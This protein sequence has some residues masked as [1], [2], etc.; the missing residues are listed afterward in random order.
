MLR[1]EH[2]ARAVG[3]A[4]DH[5]NRKLTAGHVQHLRRV[6]DDLIDRHQAEVPRHEFNDGP[7]SAH[8]RADAQSRETL[9]GNRRVDDPA[10]AEL[11]EHTLTDF[12]R[13][14][15]VADF[16]AHQKYV[17]VAF[18]FFGHGAA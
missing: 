18:H 16:F 15:V 1:A 3:S 6:I 5:R 17:G 4:K 13:A 2:T 7:Q 12:V 10:F 8:G 11:F 9:F 14:L